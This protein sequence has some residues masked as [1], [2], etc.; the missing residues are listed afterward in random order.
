VDFVSKTKGAELIT[1]P[2]V[3]HG[4]SKWSDFMPQWKDA[5][6][7]LI[8]TYEKEKPA[9]VDAVRLKSSFSYY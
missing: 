8:A 2:K 3:G 5:I 4:F 6:S 9:K 1:L 7:R